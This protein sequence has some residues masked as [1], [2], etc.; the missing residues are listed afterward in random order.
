[1]EN[2]DD[3]PNFMHEGNSTNGKARSGRQRQESSIRMNSDIIKFIYKRKKYS[4][5]LSIQLDKLHSEMVLIPDQSFIKVTKRPS[6]PYIKE[7]NKQCNSI[8]RTFCGRFRKEYFQLKDSSLVRKRLP[9]LGDILQGTAA[10]YWIEN[11]NRKL[12]VMIEQ[13]E[14]EQILTK[15]REFLKNIEEDNGKERII[16]IMAEITF[17]LIT[18]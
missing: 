6:S 16:R 4:Q 3:D 9:K 12:T 10:A 18:E 1:M 7:W 2:D 17:I 11:N 13:G 14:R 5:E 15:V 8:V